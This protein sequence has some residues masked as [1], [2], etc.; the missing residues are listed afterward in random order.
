MKK[1]KNSFAI[2]TILFTFV[3][4]TSG[5]SKGGGGNPDPGVY[6]LS[7]E[8]TANC[9]IVSSPGQY[10]FTGTV[11]GGSTESVGT[12]VSAEVLWESFGTKEMP[13]KGDVV[14]SVSYS[15]G[16]VYFT[17]GEDGNAVIAVKDVNDTI[18]WSWHIW[19]CEGFNPVTSAQVYNNGAGTMMDRN[20]GATSATPGDVKALGLLY[21]WGR[22]DPFP[23]S[24]SIYYDSTPQRAASTGTWPDARESNM[25]TGTFSFVVQNP[26][27]F[28]KFC[29][30]TYDWYYM[31]VP[32]PSTM[33]NTRWM[34]SDTI[35]GLYDPCPPG[36]RV[37]D[38]DTAGVW[39]TAF[40]TKS[41]W[42]TA[43][44]DDTNKGMHFGT[45]EKTLGSGE[46]WYPATGCINKTNTMN[47]TGKYGYLWSSTPGLQLSNYRNVF[48]LFIKNDGGVDP[49]FG[50]NR[51]FA[52]SVRCAK[53]KE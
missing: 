27:T 34:P 3:L 49:L 44:W 46:I 47:S 16:K 30:M 13:V 4:Y 39:A 6:D 50:Q 5:C 22:K 45:T 26:M 51:A 21:Q 36:W 7:A 24:D 31:A 15:N 53:E 35:K 11:K 41:S 25:K 1:M 40:G 9:Y 12:P 52:F 32:S 29:N 33:E 10:C 17:S 37:P 20:L 2:A 23:G 48:I 28:I 14:D 42:T 8:G 38:G 43:N 19:V 18:L